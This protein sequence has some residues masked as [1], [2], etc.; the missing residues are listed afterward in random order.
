LAADDSHGTS[1]SNAH[2]AHAQPIPASPPPSFRSRSPSLTLRRNQTVDPTLADAFESDNDASEDE[3]D[4]RQRLVRRPTAEQQP[5]QR[6]HAFSQP[7]ASSASAQH[8]ASSGSASTAGASSNRP[9]LGRVFGGGMQSDGVFSNLS[10]RP[11]VGS[12]V[13]KDE[14]PPVCLSISTIPKLKSIC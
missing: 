9:I 12:Q 10:A 4:V 2:A 6:N 14:A 1:S 13:E 11:E 7:V 5:Q 8:S 3:D